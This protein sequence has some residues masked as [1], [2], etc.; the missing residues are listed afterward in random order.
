MKQIQ[1][2]VEAREKTGGGA[3]GRLRRAGNIPAVLYGR[4]GNQNLTLKEQNFHLML[5]EM[6]GAS[7]LIELNENGGKK[8]LA[9]LRDMQRDSCTNRF[10]HVDFQEISEQEIVT[11]RIRLMPIGEATGVKNENGLLEILDH[12]V[13]VTCLPKHIPDFIRIDVADLHV[14]DRI[15][16][17][18]LPE[19]EGVT[20]TSSPRHVLIACTGK[21]AK[22]ADGEGETSG[23]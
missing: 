8:V 17:K 16:V 19:I 3:A 23:S 4:S 21:K 12:T 1:I 10:L 14:G 9:L 5:R 2:E 18:Q 11:T 7:A 22:A 13:E 15:E 6:N 20:Y